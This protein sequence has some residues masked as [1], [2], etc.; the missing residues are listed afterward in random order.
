MRV[1]RLLLAALG[2]IAATL[3]AA[4]GALSLL[5]RANRWAAAESVPV[6]TGAPGPRPASS[7]RLVRAGG[8]AAHLVGPM[9]EPRILSALATWDPPEPRGA[10]KVLTAIWAAPLTAAGLACALGS[11]AR[12]R[13][14]PGGWCVVAD[15]GLLAAR[16]RHGGFAAM[17]LGQVVLARHEPSAALWAHEAAHVRQALWLGPIMAVGY[18]LCHVRYGYTMNPF[19]R[20]ARHAAARALSPG[21]RA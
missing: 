19:E 4:V 5:R 10:A 2:A 9:T 12:P 16:L 14:R 13:R 8:S 7:R 17:T 15:R 11:G 1:L 6:L 3:G 21:D 18:P 20:G